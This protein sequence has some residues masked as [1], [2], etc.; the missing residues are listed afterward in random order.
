M[1]FKACSQ[2]S[3]DPAKDPALVRIC[4]ANPQWYMKASFSGIDVSGINKKGQLKNTMT[5]F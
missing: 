2:A 4:H 3:F 1:S 5:A